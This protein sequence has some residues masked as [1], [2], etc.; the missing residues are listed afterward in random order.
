VPPEVPL[1]ADLNIAGGRKTEMGCF[2]GNS[3]EFSTG[4][5]KHHPAASCFIRILIMF[6][7]LAGEEGA[8]VAGFN[9]PQ[10]PFAVNKY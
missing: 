2:S 6:L 7:N 8:V 3:A 5:H 10:E 4:H 1:V 9:E